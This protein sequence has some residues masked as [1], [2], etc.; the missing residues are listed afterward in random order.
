MQNG[1]VDVNSEANECMDKSTQ[2][3]PVSKMADN[4]AFYL[5]PGFLMLINPIAHDLEIL[6]CRTH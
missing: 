1:L 4:G 3:T 5:N 6:C 2:S